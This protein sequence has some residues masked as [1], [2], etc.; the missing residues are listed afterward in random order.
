MTLIEA[1]DTLK[2]FAKRHR[3][4]Y[5]TTCHAISVVLAALENGP[6]GT[7]GE[8]AGQLTL[9]IVDHLK[10]ETDGAVVL[11]AIAAATVVELDRFEKTIDEFTASLRQLKSGR[12]AEL[13]RRAKEN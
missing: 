3:P 2:N 6:T 7:V 10:K 9:D 11:T 8:R 1:I 13:T 4:T 5:A 12:D